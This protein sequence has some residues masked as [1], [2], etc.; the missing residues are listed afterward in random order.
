MNRPLPH[1]TDLERSILASILLNPETRES[2]FNSITVIA[3]YHTKHQI[4]YQ[5]AYSLFRQGDPPDLQSVVF[6]IIESGLIEQ[7]GGAAYVS[8]LLD[9]PVPVSVEYTSKKLM[10]LTE[11]RRLYIEC[12][13]IVQDACDLGKPIDEVL[14]RVDSVA[15]GAE[16]ARKSRVPS[17][18][19]L[20]ISNEEWYQSKLTPDCI[21]EEYLFKDVGTFSAP[22]GTGKTTLCLNEYIHIVLG[23]SLYG[24]EVRKP[25]WCLFITAEDSRERLVA[26]LREIAKAMEL[27]DKE[28]AMIRSEILFWDVSGEDMRLISLVDGNIVLTGMADE[29]VHTYKDNPPAIVT[30]DPIISFG[31][32]ESRVND[33]EQGLIT[34]AR[35]IRNGLN[36]AVR[37][38]GHTGKANARDKTLDQYSTRGG[39]ALPDGSRLVTILQRY[40]K[41]D[42]T[43]RPP[44]GCTPSINSSI[45]ILARPKLSYAKPNLPLIWI[46]RT[47]W[48]FEYSTETFL[49]DEEKDHVLLDLVEKFLFIEE[50]GGVYHSKTSLEEKTKDLG[51]TRKEMRDAV[52]QLL[53]SGRIV[54]KDL[55][56]EHR[57]GGRKTYLS[58]LEDLA[59]YGG[60]EQKYQTTPPGNSDPTTPAAL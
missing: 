12:N 54:E 30:F 33:N 32:G 29:I 42:N 1:D 46:K 9:I 43:H 8:G 15:R 2:I 7:V 60:I 31:V 35:R 17:K 16:S 22:G 26:R 44:E 57:Q 5:A 47:G 20:F 58:V 25:G 23:R 38:I 45:S 13:A 10:E 49:S 6:A 21:V 40:D 41:R 36:C 59:G 39:S 53:A 11:R 37:L 19:L 27:N 24:L 56:K 51:L 3:L 50:A 48:M 4:I 34:A 28:L 18:E 52:T 14:T 55:P